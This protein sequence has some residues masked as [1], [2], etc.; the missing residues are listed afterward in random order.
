MSKNRRNKRAATRATAPA[1]TPTPTSVQSPADVT[2]GRALWDQFQRIGGGVTPATVSNILRMADSGQP[3]MLVDL[4]NETR[5]K[6]G[7]IQGACGTRESA[8]GLCDLD[9]IIPENPSRKEKKALAV[10]RE[11]YDDF[12]NW[13]LLIDHLSGNSVHFGHGTAEILPWQITR[14]GY[15]LPRECKQ[16]HA[17]DFIFAQADGALRYATTSGDTVGVDLL[18]ENPGRIVQLQRRIVGDV[19]VR[20]GLARILIWAGLFRNWSLRDWI[21]LGEVGWKPWRIAKYEPGS[22][23]PDGGTS[24]DIDGLLRVLERLAQMGAAAVPKSTDIDV[25]WPKNQTSGQGSVHKEL[26]DTLGR[27]ISKALL[28][29]TTS[30]ESGPNGTRSDTATRDRVRGDIREGDCR[31]L[32]SALRYQLF[33]PAVALNVGSDVRC[34]V[35]WFQTEE[36]ADIRSFSQAVKTLRDAGLRIGAKWVRDEIGMPEPREGEEMLEAPSKPEPEPDPEEPD[37]ADAEEQD[38]DSEPA[39]AA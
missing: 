20:E 2:S 25:A 31:A 38:D 29:Q 19:P 4:F 37:D 27:E 35:P 3:A 5:Q 24:D 33:M 39:K 7:H 26:F 10:C 32:A 28:G 1:K 22:L 17:R 23:I 9:F 30:I 12:R 11:L 6:D 13:S 16:L 15:L 14:S 21:A 36:N 34:P 8:P 18:A